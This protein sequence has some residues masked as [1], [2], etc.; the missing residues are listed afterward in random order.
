MDENNTEAFVKYNYFHRE[1]RSRYQSN[2]F[3]QESLYHNAEQDYYVCPMGEHMSRIGIKRD[4]TASGYITKSIRYQATRCQGCPLRSRCFK[5]QGNRIIEVNHRLNEYKRKA[6]ERLTSEGGVK[7][8]GRR[9]IEP[10][11]VFGQMKYN[12]TYRRFRHVG[13]EKVTMAFA[14][15]AMAFNLKKMCAKM[16][17]E[18]F[19]GLNC[20]KNTLKKLYSG[21]IIALNP[22]ER[23]IRRKWAA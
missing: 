20:M 22:V 16:A 17:K 2:P 23:E 3:H 5:A 12:M 18:A 10:E 9:C 21:E 19:A 7:F 11:A 14:F 13:K 4:K 1:Q 15:F 6:C 8:R